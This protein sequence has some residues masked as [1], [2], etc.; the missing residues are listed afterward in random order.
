MKIP[1]SLLML[2]MKTKFWMKS[3]AEYLDIFVVAMKVRY[4][5]TPNM[6]WL[7]AFSCYENRF[8]K[9]FLLSKLFFVKIYHY[10]LFEGTEI[11]KWCLV[12]LYSSCHHLNW[13][14]LFIRDFKS[15][16]LFNFM[17]MFNTGTPLLTY[18]CSRLVWSK[19]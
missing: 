9:K 14:K 8:C 2:L 19:Q 13:P 5:K 6:T 1:I 17:N 7:G 10:E 3:T 12:T 11:G 4:Q 16:D 18:S 15:K